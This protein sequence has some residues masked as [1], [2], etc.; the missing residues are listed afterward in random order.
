MPSEIRMKRLEKLALQR[1]SEIVLFELSDPRL[2]FLTLTRIEIT[3]D[4]SYGTIFWST[5]GNDADRNKIAHALAAGAPEVQRGIAAVFHTRRSPR[6]TFEFDPSIEGS[7]RV[8]KVL[9]DLKSE[10][11]ELEAERGGDE[12][13]DAEAVT[14]GSESAESQDGPE[15]AKPGDTE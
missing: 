9:D 7:I 12:D 15:P 6:I 14:D 13:G 4:L 8:S 1:A 3:N 2:T 10:R 5:I 11:D